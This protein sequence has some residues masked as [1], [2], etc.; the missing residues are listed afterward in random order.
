MDKIVEFEIIGLSSKSE[1]LQEGEILSLEE[2]YGCV[3]GLPVFEIKI[4]HFDNIFTAQIVKI[5]DV[6]E[7]FEIK[8]KLRS[9]DAN[10]T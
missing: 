10:H 6:S 5:L 7:S 4:N 9:E 2:I 3:N 8:S 1:D